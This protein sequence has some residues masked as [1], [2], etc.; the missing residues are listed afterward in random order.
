MNN[1]NTTTE[2]ETTTTTTTTT[3]GDFEIEDLE[4]VEVRE[5]ANA[6]SCD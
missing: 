4:L 3:N 5:Q 6:M 2:E 1:E